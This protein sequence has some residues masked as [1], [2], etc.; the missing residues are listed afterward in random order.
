MWVY[1]SFPGLVVD[2]FISAHVLYES[3]ISQLFPN[4]CIFNLNTAV[5][6]IPPGRTQITELA[7]RH[8]TGALPSLG[9]VV[10]LSV[11]ESPAWDSVFSSVPPW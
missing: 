8:A 10:A 11:R 9:Q 6:L 3:R 5:I 1:H 7:A 4:E 2:L